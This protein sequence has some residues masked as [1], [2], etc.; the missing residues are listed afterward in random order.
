MLSLNLG[1]GRNSMTRRYLRGYSG[2]QSAF[3]AL[4]PKEQDGFLMP[5]CIS[6]EWPLIES[7]WKASAREGL[8]MNLYIYY[9]IIPNFCDKI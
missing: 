7:D 4:F 2:P 8:L 9:K 5:S 1:Q 6:D 3:R